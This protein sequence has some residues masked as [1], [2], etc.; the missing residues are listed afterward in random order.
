MG[1]VNTI[2]RERL[3]VCTNHDE[4]RK[5]QDAREVAWRQDVRCAAIP[6]DLPVQQ[7]FYGASIVRYATVMRRSIAV[8]STYLC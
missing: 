8:R 3:K 5:S 6:S 4:S 2:T 7:T 1:I